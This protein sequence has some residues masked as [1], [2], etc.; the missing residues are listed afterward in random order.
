MAEEINID[1][2]TRDV[3]IK[4]LVLLELH[5]GEFSNAPLFCKSCVEKHLY[6]CEAASQECIGTCKIGG[7]VWHRVA[8]WAYNTRQELPNLTQEQADQLKAEARDFRKELEALSG[9]P[10]IHTSG[11]LTDLP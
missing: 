2:Y 11:H 4:N 5:Y 3:L 7:N 9:Q 8:K 1:E 10:E 6:I